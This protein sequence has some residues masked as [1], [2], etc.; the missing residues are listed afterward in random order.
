MKN[1]DLSMCLYD[2]TSLQVFVC[3]TLSQSFVLIKR[4]VREDE[5]LKRMLINIPHCSHSTRIVR[6]LK[7]LSYY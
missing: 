4:V 7:S 1:Y 2:E 6:G 5:L 3:F